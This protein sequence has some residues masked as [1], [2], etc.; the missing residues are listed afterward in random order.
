MQDGL[1]IHNWKTKLIGSNAQ[2]HHSSL[3][4]LNTKETAG[5]STVNSPG[6]YFLREPRIHEELSRDI[7]NPHRAGAISRNFTINMS[8]QCRAFTSALQTEKLKDP[9]FPGP[10]G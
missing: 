7:F 4:Q 8:P 6:I 3:S 9:L 2:S 10:V 5:Y 1:V